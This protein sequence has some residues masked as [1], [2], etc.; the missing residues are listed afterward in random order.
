MIDTGILPVFT[1]WRGIKIIEKCD[2][3]A[4]ED[5]IPNGDPVR[6]KTKRLNPATFADDY[7]VADPHVRVDDRAITDLA[8]PDVGKILVPDY[9]PQTNLC[10]FVQ[11]HEFPPSTYLPILGKSYT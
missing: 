5:V 3:R 7:L 10:C 9:D 4:N 1:E 11:T 8:G 6:D 2:A